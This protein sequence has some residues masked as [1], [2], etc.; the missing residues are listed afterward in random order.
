MKHS[1]LLPSF[2][3]TYSLKLHLDTS[4]GLRLRNIKCKIL[5]H[6][7]VW[8]LPNSIITTDRIASHREICMHIV[9]SQCS[10]DALYIHDEQRRG[11]GVNVD[12]DISPHRWGQSR[13]TINYAPYPRRKRG[14]FCF[15]SLVSRVMYPCTKL[16]LL[17]FPAR[18]T[19]KTWLIHYNIVLTL[20]LLLLRVITLRMFAIT[21][22]QCN[23]YESMHHVIRGKSP[24]LDHSTLF[25][26]KIAWT[27]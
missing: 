12:E 21:T 27:S 20:M 9:R 1:F 5:L 8:S 7:L 3:S 6:L 4:G 10:L 11:C 22:K 26:C 2:S 13:M 19:P 18:T 24:I 16:P 14:P 17:S 15:G 25:N 23:T